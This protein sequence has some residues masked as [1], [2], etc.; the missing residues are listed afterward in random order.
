ME[1]KDETT[2]AEFE[3]AVNKMKKNKSTGI[4]TV[5]VEVWQG[6]TVAKE[7]VFQFLSEIW[8]KEEVPIELAVAVLIMIFKNK[9]SP[10]D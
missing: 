1:E 10:E 4:D 9:G 6:S 2:R 7:C 3:H 8:K 5:P